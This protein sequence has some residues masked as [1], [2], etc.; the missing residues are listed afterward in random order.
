M[1]A[2]QK[3]GKFT[4]LEK[5]GQGGMADVYLAEANY[6]GLRKTVALKRILQA[7][8]ANAHFRDTFRY[9]A[10]L[11]MELNHPNVVQ[12]F[13]YGQASPQ[14]SDANGCLYMVMEFVDGV[15][16]MKLIRK[17]TELARPLPLGLSAYIISEVLR[18]LDYAHRL[19]GPDGRPL[20]LVHRDMSPQ[21]ILLSREGAVKVTDFGIA[22]ALGRYEEEGILRG[23]LHYM[24]PEQARTDPVDG[25]SDVFAVGLILYEM[26]SGTHPYSAFK[27]HKALEAARRAEITPPSLLNASIP[28]EL[29]Q[30]LRRALAPRKEDRYQRSKEMQ[31][32]LSRFLHSLPDLVDAT[33]LVDAVSDR[34]PEGSPHRAAGRAG[35]GTMA[36]KEVRL[37]GT[38]E[39]DTGRTGHEGHLTL[40]THTLVVKFKESKSLVSM[41]V[42]VLNVEAAAARIG[43]ERVTQLVDQFGVMIQNILLKDKQNRYRYRREDATT[44]LVVRG[45]PYTGEYD[46]SELLRDAHKMRRDFAV[47]REVAPELELGI[48][49]YRLAVELE[50]D[51]NVIHW[52][53]NPVEFQ[54]ALRWAHMIPGEIIVSPYIYAAAKYNWE[55]E[56]V[57]SDPEN[58]VHRLLRQKDRD[59][60]LQSRVGSALIGRGFELDRLRDLFHHVRESSRPDHLVVLGE[61]G[62]GKS[63]LLQEFLRTSKVKLELIRAESRPYLQYAPFA[64]IMDF[65]RDFARLNV[66]AKGEDSLLK[67]YTALTHVVP[68][69]ENRE[70]ILKA[71]RPILDSRPDEGT[72]HPNLG[73]LVTR[74]LEILI[75]SVAQKRPV[76]AVFED[77]QWADEQ[78]KRI[79][80]EL[81]E[82]NRI[83]GPVMFVFTGRERTDIPPYFLVTRPV[84]LQAMDEETS[85]KFVSSR[86]AAPEQVRPLIEAVIAKGEGNP[87]YLNEMIASLVDTGQCRLEGPE[88][89]LVLN[90]ALP[91][92]LDVKLFPTLEGILSARLDALSPDLRRILRIAAV[93]GRKFSKKSLDAACGEDT[94]EALDAF[95]KKQLIRPPDT[96]GRHSFVQSMMRDYAYSSLPQ[97]ERAAAHRVQA[98]SMIASDGYKPAIDDVMIARHLELSDQ[99]E[100]A[101]EFY[102]AAAHH[103]RKLGTNANSEAIRHYDKVL[104][105]VPDQKDMVYHAHRDRETILRSQGRR[106]EQL[107][108]V[109]QMQRLA[110]GEK[111]AEWLAEALCREMAYLQETGESQKVNDLFPRAFGAA[112]AVED[113][114]YQVDA[115]RILARAKVEMGEIDRS[116]E[117][118]H[119]AL[120]LLDEH[121]KIERIRADVMH[122]MGNALF[123]RGRAE[124]AMTAYEEALSLYRK[125]QR[126]TQESTILM[127]LG[128]ISAM[129][130][131]YEKALE[132]Y[133]ASYDIDREKGDRVYTGLKLANLAQAHIDLGNYD[134]ARGL[135]KQARRLCE[136][137]RDKSALADA[138]FTSAL[139]R[140]RLDRHDDS[141]RYIEEGLRLAR[142]ADSRLDE[143]RGLLLW[144]EC[145]LE[146]PNGSAHEAGQKAIEAAKLA[147]EAET[148][149]EMVHAF[150]LQAR[151][152]L[153][154]GNAEEAI[155]RSAHAVAFTVVQPVPGVEVVYYVH[156]KIMQTLG[157]TGWARM[158]LSRARD[159]IMRKA[160][161]LSQD[162]VREIYLSVYPAREILRDYL[163]FIQS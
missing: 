143:I 158:F 58:P 150:S 23:K 20:E 63:A 16:L 92:E 105:L 127:N 153:K 151:A 157:R 59:E 7:L 41:A 91:P 50:H 136:Q 70:A 146:N 51:H 9:E 22:K 39:G 26:V 46:E 131:H 124:E 149:A 93:L 113:P 109:R 135:V 61:M 10:E 138:Y 148:P 122:V 141:M 15:D 97:E 30:I 72:A 145:Q 128:F 71:F 114:S 155:G 130:G 118:L 3:I 42:R 103:A 90:R 108:E 35:T 74:A 57:G 6:N 81:R 129:R 112:Q 95:V 56:P 85:R 48:C 2:V 79:L 18:G 21:N 69:E 13:E 73:I 8:S 125:Y 115:L 36:S 162:K 102:L 40:D 25:R 94:A 80:Q 132:Y 156:G 110:E 68:D 49:A 34:F 160:N 66:E 120:S 111:N 32:D 86:F 121:P 116:L 37:T 101:A 99:K 29:E 147:Q 82:R 89:K 45:I 43:A 62:V 24:S 1:E 152:L 60:R 84:V 4:L 139:L 33:S 104:E 67:L 64:F 142:E 17:S 53:V 19:T 38:Q 47:Y 52:T 77:M 27:G 11:S 96:D 107:E 161:L 126:H 78:S 100:K 75:A 88:R 65:V 163:R 12:V 159:E 144:A 54:E 137:T 83:R 123:Y 98:E 119:S 55:M 76:L 154:L 44:F 87:F 31:A 133:K 117:L 106:E 140:L 14:E 5:I 134:Q 28:V